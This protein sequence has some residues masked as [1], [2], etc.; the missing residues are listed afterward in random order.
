MWKTHKIIAV[1]P[2]GLKTIAFIKTLSRDKN[3]S[4][5]WKL[6][7]DT[8]NIYFLD[9]LKG[10][11]YREAEE[12]TLTCKAIIYT[13]YMAMLYERYNCITHI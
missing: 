2:T 6:N 8:E 11:S 13:F 1:V 7:L 5:S 3:C 4:P 12:T 10:Q 9:G